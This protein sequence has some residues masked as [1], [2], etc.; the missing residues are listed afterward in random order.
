MVRRVLVRDVPVDLNLDDHSAVGAWLAKSLRE[1][2]ITAGW[3]SATFSIGREHVGLKRI[4]LP[5]TDPVELPEMTRLAMQRELPFDAESAIID[6]VVVERHETS[7]TVL[8]VAVPR[9]RIESLQAVAAAAGLK[10]R[11]IALRTMGAA[12]LMNTLLETHSTGVRVEDVGRVR[13]D[14]AAS[15]G[16]A[17]QTPPSSPPP[18]P[19]LATLAIDVVGEGVEFCVLSEGSIRFSRAAE[20]PA[21]Q[22]ELAIAEAVV[23]EARRTW[24]SYRVG[25][26]AGG[27]GEAVIMG[28]RRVA[29]YA[30]G[31]VGEMLKMPVRVL[32][33][34]PHIE[35]APS[36]KSSGDGSRSG[37]EGAEGDLSRV[38]PLV[39]LLLEE[40][41][42][43]ER[44]DFL[45][46][47]KAPD[48]GA[49]T[50]QRRLLVAAAIIAVGGV[51][52]TV[53]RMDLRSLR[54]RAESLVQ[55]R[56]QG[57][58]AFARAYR[59]TYKIEHL[60][61]WSSVHVDWLDHAMFLAQ[62]APPPTQIVLDSWSGTLNFPG[63]TFDA[64]SFKWGAEHQATIVID[65]EARNRATAD[66]FREALIQ[67]P[68]YAASTTGADAR[69]GKRM[70]FGFTYRLRTRAAA[71][72]DST[73]ETPSSVA[74]PAGRDSGKPAPSTEDARER[75]V[76]QSHAERP[77]QPAG[78]SADSR[79][80]AQAAQQ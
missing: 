15:A 51:A 4:T 26:E 24:M 76:G 69:G 29:E 68:I 50:R 27:I 62:V 17:G 5:T 33:E 48:V 43:G 28:D 71:P 23:T 2:G 39:G 74:I 21:P 65:G 38:W 79:D 72:E 36:G 70:P 55:Q 49:R 47:R 22:D 58:N 56:D 46:P 13:E 41:T 14:V 42:Q 30:A 52:F 8:A 78:P 80:Q 3:A 57:A 61:Q 32:R 75:S 73:R 12:A 59:N 18:P 19:P 16:A 20:V 7:T 10:V 1:A 37:S 60:R 45:H 35:H 9:T 31:P 25:D 66:A 11:R 77:A 44:I 34:H 67:N 40:E 6:F 53:M 54:A 63:V 64:K